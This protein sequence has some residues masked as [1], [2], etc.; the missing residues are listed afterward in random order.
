MKRCWLCKKFIWPWQARFV[1]E[2]VTPGR[3]AEFRWHQKCYW[4]TYS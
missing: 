2:N 3:E 4:M 1:I